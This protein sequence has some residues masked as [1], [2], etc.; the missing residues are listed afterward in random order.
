[1][2]PVVEKLPVRGSNNYALVNGPSDPSPPVT[3]TCPLGSRVALC[4]DLALV[5]SAV[6]ANEPAD[7]ALKPVVRSAAAEITRARTTIVRTNLFIVCT[8][9]ILVTWSSV[10]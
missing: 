2:L 3:K 9:Q 1:M 8:V 10:I 7:C 6:P 5:M 4:P